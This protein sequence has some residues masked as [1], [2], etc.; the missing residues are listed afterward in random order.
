MHAFSDLRGGLSP[1][2]A[3]HATLSP[4]IAANKSS[5]FSAMVTNFPLRQAKV[6]SLRWGES[7]KGFMGTRNRLC[8]TSAAQP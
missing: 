7:R 8:F 6:V 2:M 1:A 3:L 5:D 4:N